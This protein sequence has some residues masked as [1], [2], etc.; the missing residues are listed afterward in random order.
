[1][2][3]WSS[4]ARDSM[5]DLVGHTIVPEASQPTRGILSAV[6]EHQLAKWEV[7]VTKSPYL[8]INEA[9]AYKHAWIIPVQIIRQSLP[10]GYMAVT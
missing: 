1:M 5:I 8:A 2:E 9:T 3:S 4:R 10:K 7:W 6:Q